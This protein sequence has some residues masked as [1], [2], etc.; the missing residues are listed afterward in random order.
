VLW[1]DEG[2]MLILVRQ[3]QQ[4]TAAAADGGKINGELES[5]E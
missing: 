4:R 5:G 3:Q 2:H 1:F